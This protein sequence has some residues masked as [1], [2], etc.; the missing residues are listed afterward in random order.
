MGLERLDETF[1]GIAEMDIQQDKL[2]LDMPL[3]IDDA[4]V[5]STG[6]VVEDL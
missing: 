2:E 3:L 1:S 4:P 5:V 6:F